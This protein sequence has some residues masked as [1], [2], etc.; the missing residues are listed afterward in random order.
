MILSEFAYGGINLTKVQ[1][2]P[3]KKR[4]GEYMFFVDLEGHLTVEQGEEENPQGI[5]HTSHRKQSSCCKV[6]HRGRDP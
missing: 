2:R 5:E 1:S 6:V 4:L 3:T